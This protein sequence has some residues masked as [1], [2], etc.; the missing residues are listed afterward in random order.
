MI[1]VVCSL[2]QNCLQPNFIHVI[3]RSRE[4]VSESEILEFR[5]C[6]RSRTFYFRLR[7]PDLN[8][9]NIAL[10]CWSLKVCRSGLQKTSASSARPELL[11]C[12]LWQVL[13]FAPGLTVSNVGFYYFNKGG[14]AA[15]F[16]VTSIEGTCIDRCGGF[17]YRTEGERHDS[18]NLTAWQLLF[19]F[20]FLTSNMAQHVALW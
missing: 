19:C 9:K 18:K 12:F 4:S 16:G 17:S 7:N 13:P 1:S 14:K 10:V 2:L 6:S 3:I 8:C 20:V 5:C 11:L 15:A